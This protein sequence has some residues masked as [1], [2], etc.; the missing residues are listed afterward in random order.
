METHAHHLTKASEKKWSHYLFEFLML[1]LA[2]FCGFLAE[3]FREHQVEHKREQQFAGQLLSDLRK[4]SVFFKKRGEK[5]DSIFAKSWVKELFAQKPHPADGEVIRSFLKQFW[6]FDLSLTNTTFTQMKTSGSLRY[7]RNS[8]LTAELQRYYDVL[9]ERVITQ[10][11][12]SRSFF[13]DY[14]MSWYVK[15]IKTQDLGGFGDSILNQNTT[16]IDRTDR[17]DQEILNITDTYRLII[18][19]VHERMFKPAAKQA[20]E[21]ITMLKHEYHLK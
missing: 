1:F 10:S 5:L 2:V 17:T 9:S 14:L 13:D 8:S 16:I 6:S 4:D 3:N 12:I 20:D 15:H 7:I 11:A 21:L 19:S 18:L